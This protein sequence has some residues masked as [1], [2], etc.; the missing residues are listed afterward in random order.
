VKRSLI[1]YIPLGAVITHPQRTIEKAGLILFAGILLGIF[2]PGYFYNVC[3]VF[4]RDDI[5]TIL[6]DN[7]KINPNPRPTWE[8]YQKTTQGLQN[9]LS[10]IDVRISIAGNPVAGISA[11]ND[12]SALVEQRIKLQS[13]L[14][15]VKENPPF[16]LSGFYLES[17]MIMW[18]AFY[19]CLAWLIFILAPDYPRRP[20]ILRWI[21]LFIGTLVLYRWPTWMRNVPGL[22]YIERHIYASGNW[23]VSV[24]SFFVQ[25][26][27]AVL[28]CILLVAVW[29]IWAD[30]IPVWQEQV[31]EC[32]WGGDGNK[33]RLPE[34]AESFV[35]LFVHWQ[36]CSLILA[37]AFVPYTFFFWDYVIG[38]GDKRYL[39]HALI[40]HGIWGV[41]WLLISTPLAW[42]W[43][44][45]NVRY[46]LRAKMTLQ[47]SKPG[48]QPSGIDMGTLIG[49]WN[50]IGSFA[51]AMVAFGFP[52]VKEIFTHL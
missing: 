52:I 29:A 18:P 13:A 30:F 32:L 19:T 37:G 10:A 16:H 22:R 6:P 15:K 5:A 36:V 50:V 31:R 24:G 8:A 25:E 7:P 4:Y 20:E 48:E 47:R 34:F 43:Y 39:A 3:H 26:L 35:Q 33:D 38:Y 44:Q 2:I 21:P 17:L 45:W 14:D 28:A 9:A 51:G 27:Q 1:C 46:K 41:T 11:V 40:M 42:T 23:D 12:I 49:S